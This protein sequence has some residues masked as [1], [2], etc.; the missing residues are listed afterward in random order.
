MKKNNVTGIILLILSIVS[1]PICFA[2][3][4]LVGE[5]EIFGIGG[6]VYYSWIIYFAAFVSAASLGF[7][8]HAK[9]NGYHHKKNMV[10]ALIVI[11]ISIIFGSYRFVFSSNF[12]YSNK[13]L[14]SVNQKTGLSIPTSGKVVTQKE[15]LFLLGNAKIT[16]GKNDF[17]I[18][19]TG[20]WKS[21]LSSSIKNV[22]P[23]EV[24]VQT[25]QFD[26]FTFY[27]C[28]AAKYN[29]VSYQESGNSCV[30]LAYQQS[31]GRLMILDEYVYKA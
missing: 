27:D 28:D 12:D 16:F 2:V 11:P 24:T 22:L 14:V 3:A 10:I 20:N 30:F 4:C 26:C 9:R 17:E 23:H 6:I 7:A 1:A 18:G 25:T 31:S 19:L 13:I 21:S 5:S 29:E 15:K 8:L